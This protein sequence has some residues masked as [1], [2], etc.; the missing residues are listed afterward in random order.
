MSLIKNV[1]FLGSGIFSKQVCLG[2]AFVKNVYFLGFG[3]FS[4]QTF[5]NS[6]VVFPP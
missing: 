3:I 4:K 1:Y 6:V 5:I 2:M